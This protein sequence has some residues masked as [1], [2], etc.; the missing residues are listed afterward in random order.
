MDA[1]LEFIEKYKHVYLYGAGVNG[2]FLADSLQARHIKISGFVVTRRKTEQTRILGW[3]LLELSELEAVHAQDCGFIFALGSNYHTEVTKALEIAGFND[4]FRLP[5]TFFQK[6]KEAAEKMSLQEILELWPLTEV[7]CLRSIS[8]N[9]ILLLRLDGIG[10]VVLFTPFLRALRQAHPESEITLI[11]QPVVYNLMETCPY[12]D[13]LLAYEWREDS[14][15]P[16][17]ARCRHAREYM[18]EHGLVGRYDI[19]LNPRWG[20]DYYDAG[21]LAYFSEAP[22]RVAWSEHVLPI[23]SKLNCGFD[24]FYTMTML[25]KR[26]CHEVEHNM[27]FLAQLGIDVKSLN[28]LNGGAQ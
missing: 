18:H 4:F 1:L 19:V 16:L 20:E 26:I 8:W 10:D 24:N 23:K 11:V 13:H 9:R 14:A 17:R 15:W 21:A 25:D 3:P 6:L 12:I 2:V 27:Q 28:K 7:D 5:D 22:C